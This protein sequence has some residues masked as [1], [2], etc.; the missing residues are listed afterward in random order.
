MSRAQICLVKTLNGIDCAGPREARILE[1]T[2][3][4]ADV[5]STALRSWDNQVPGVCMRSY[6]RGKSEHCSEL[7]TNLEAKGTANASG[8]ILD[9]LEREYVRV[10]SY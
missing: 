5:R 8:D 7:R 3:V 1:K 6:G 9:V 2:V 4:F 10:C